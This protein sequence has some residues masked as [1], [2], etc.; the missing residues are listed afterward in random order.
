VGVVY[1]SSN[2]GVTWSQIPSSSFPGPAGFASVSPDRGL[3]VKGSAI[4][5]DGKYQVLTT[6]V[7]KY[8]NTVSNYDD[9]F[10]T[11]YVSSDYGL[12][13]ILRQYE[14]YA[15]FGAYYQATI[16]SNGQIILVTAGN[17]IV[18][19]PYG[20]IYRSVN[21]GATFTLLPSTVKAAQGAGISISRDGSK[22]IA[23]YYNSTNYTLLTYS[24]DSGATWNN[25]TNG[26]IPSRQWSSVAI[27]NDTVS[28][29]TAYATTSTSRNLS[30]IVNID[31]TPTITEVSPIKNASGRLSVSSSGQYII[32][33][34]NPIG[35]WRSFNYGATFNYIT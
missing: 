19:P 14:Y 4:S 25:I 33:K 21:Y 6:D 27:Y 29:T 9:Y 3:F 1:K 5:N 34:D 22:A 12:T 24:T 30:R 31:T 13:W 35:I 18:D 23:A 11:V 26:S 8:H 7:C 2:Y 15:S 20:G 32:V 28:G 10:I 17:G 16:S